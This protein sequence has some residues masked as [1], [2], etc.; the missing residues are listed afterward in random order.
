MKAPVFYLIVFKFTHGSI[1]IRNSY[2]FFAR[3][4]DSFRFSVRSHFLFSLNYLEGFNK[5]LS[6][7]LCILLFLYRNFFSKTFGGAA[8]ASFFMGGQQNFQKILRGVILGGVWMFLTPSLILQ[9]F[10]NKLLI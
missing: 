1:Q 5:N 4:L 8:K 2:D 6:F 7:Q 9:R 3:I 10:F